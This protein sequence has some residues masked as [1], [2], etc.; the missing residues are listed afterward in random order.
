[1]YQRHLIA[2][3]ADGELQ[4]ESRNARGAWKTYAG[5]LT[6]RRSNRGTKTCRG[7][8]SGTTGT[9]D[10][11]SRV[12]CPAGATVGQKVVTWTAHSSIVIPR[13]PGQS[14]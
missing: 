3:L 13:R 5:T 10:V 9:K 6:F 8:G 1:M 11:S 12:V 2:D 4:L 7:R 14:I